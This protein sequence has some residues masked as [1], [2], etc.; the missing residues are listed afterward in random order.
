MSVSAVV[1]NFYMRI[2]IYFERTIKVARDGV[3]YK[4]TIRIYNIHKYK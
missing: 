2:F 3:K 1:E 4:Y